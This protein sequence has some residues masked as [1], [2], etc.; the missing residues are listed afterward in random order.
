MLKDKVAIVTGAAS[1]IGYEV[2]LAYAKAGAKV[3]VSD[4]NVAGGQDTVTAIKRCGGDA[5]FQSCNVRKLDDHEQ[6]VA[7]AINHYGR[8]DVACNNAG[9]PGARYPLVDY[10]L[11]LWH[12]AIDINLTGVF[13]GLRT[14]IPAMQ[15]TGGGAIVNIASIAACITLEG[16][17]AYTAAKHG[18]AGLT[19]SA[20]L[21]YA[22]QG[23]RV[24]AILPGLIKTPLIAEVL[25]TQEMGYLESLHPVGRLGRPDEIAQA[26]L[27]FSTSAASFVT[28]S[29]L[30]VDGGF[31][32]R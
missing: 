22:K 24:N 18:V 1:G 3:V 4:I 15:K 32:T 8:L 19:K 27:W 31:L 29:C 25:D 23:I 13:Y 21:D 11:E 30:N 26:V 28:G 7:A 14:Q 9:I 5:I 17:P 20:A 10:P 16:T 12:D 6:L 2:A